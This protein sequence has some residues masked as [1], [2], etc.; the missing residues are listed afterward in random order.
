MDS[1]CVSSNQVV[2]ELIGMGFEFSDVSEAI[3]AV[4]P[5]LEDAIEFILNGSCR[6]STVASASSKC[7]TSNGKALGKRALSASHSSDRM[8]QST[9][10]EH[11]QSTGRP[12]RSKTNTESNVS[13]SGS[14]LLPRKQTAQKM[15]ATKSELYQ[16]DGDICAQLDHFGQECQNTKTDEYMTIMFPMAFLMTEAALIHGN[17]R[18]GLTSNQ[19]ITQ[20][21]PARAKCNEENR[22][23]I[24]GLAKRDKASAMVDDDLRRMSQNDLDVSCGEFFGHSPDKDSDICGLREINDLPNKQEEGLKLQQGHLEGST[25]IYVPTRKETLSIS[26]FFASVV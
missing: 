23:P 24:E 25:I 1:S 2:A 15:R 3:K 13:V 7:S 9:I 10:M 22:D 4:S 16:G 8:R 17:P 11:L 12:K 14:Q 21:E 6:N 20:P 26:K 19:M 18:L 5:S